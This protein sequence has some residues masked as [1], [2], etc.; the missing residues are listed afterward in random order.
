MR[1]NL[2]VLALCFAWVATCFP[3]AQTADSGPPVIIEQPNDTTVAAGSTASFKVVVG[4]SRP[5]TYQ[6]RPDYINFTVGTNDV[7]LLEDVQVG[8]AGGYLVNI[9]NSLGTISSRV[10]TLTVL[11]SGPFVLSEAEPRTASLGQ[12]MTLSPKIAGSNPRS[13]QWYKNGQPI[14]KSTKPSLTWTNIQ[15]SDAGVYTLA[16]SNQI[17]STTTEGAELSVLIPEWLAWLSVAGKAKSPGHADGTGTAARFNSPS[18]IATDATG[19]LYV[20][21]TGNSVI[22]LLSPGAGHWTASTI[23]GFAG[24]SVEQD[25]IGTAARFASPTGIAVDAAGAIYVADSAGNAIRKLERIGDDWNVSTIAGG[26]RGAADGTNALAQFA[27]PSGLAFAPDGALLVADSENHT[28]R[29]I[30]ISISTNGPQRVVTTIAGQPGTSGSA[31]GPG[32]E[33][34]FSSPSGVA[35]D[36]SGNLYVTD[37]GNGTIRKLSPVDTNWVVTTIAGKPDA[38][39]LQYA[40]GTNSRARF[41]GPTGITIDKQGNLYVA[42]SNNGLIRK[43]APIDDVWVVSAVGGLAGVKGS[44]AGANAV[45]RFETPRAIAPAANGELYIVDSGNAT[46]VRGFHPILPTFLT[47]PV[48]QFAQTNVNVTLSAF[49]IGEPAVSYRWYQGSGGN[50]PSAVSGATNASLTLTNLKTSRTVYVVATNLVGSTISLCA[51]LE[52]GIDPR[53]LGVPCEPLAATGWDRDVVAENAPQPTYSPEGFDQVGYLWKE[54]GFP[55]DPKYSANPGGLPS[56]RRFASLADPNVIF[57]F[58]PYTGNNALLMTVKTKF[59]GSLTLGRPTRLHTLAIL[60]ASSASTYTDVRLVFANGKVSKPISLSFPDWLDAPYTPDKDRRPALASMGRLWVQ[61]K[62]LSPDT[63]WDLVGFTLHHA[64]IDLVALGLSGGLLTRIDFSRS[65]R[66]IS[67]GTMGIMALSG[68]ILEEAPLGMPIVEVPPQDSTNVLGSELA[69][70][71][72][73]TGNAPLSY[74][75][76][77]NGAEVPGATSPQLVVHTSTIDDA[78]TYSVRVRNDIGQIESLGALITIRVPPTALVQASN[79]SPQ[80]GSTLTLHAVATGD[81]PMAYQWKFYGNFLLGETNQA[82]SITNI[83]QERS[84]FYFV[85]VSSP[86]GTATSPGLRIAV[87]GPS[88]LAPVLNEFGDITFGFETKP[89]F[90]FT[91]EYSTDLERWFPFRAYQGTGDP[92]GFVDRDARIVSRSFYRIITKPQ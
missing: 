38:N 67:S 77:H 23:A 78:G 28:I 48:S 51:R 9:A 86:Y 61:G 7:L 13:Y 63:T 12:P 60:G 19:N 44:A 66:T 14:S 81:G 79:T 52:V 11:E 41:W 58:E 36:S 89:G 59:A 92:I 6:W 53:P 64:D 8:R 47:S 82:L 2:Q 74:Q 25:G 1:G 35:A 4:G 32:A 21:D 76:L 10:A 18:G 37:S 39:D 75:W 54:V 24:N 34:Q 43:I 57:Q 17:S 72:T 83:L 71:L 15:S 65:A 45:A 20:A 22:R 42:D 55:T 85:T 68:S 80:I 33:A 90:T 56:S 70:T 62:V 40:D 26:S 5:F 31:D 16:V 46:I 29:R 87:V 27:G 50:T 30:S 69:L 84:G 3:Q 49:A 88:I 73:A 91:V